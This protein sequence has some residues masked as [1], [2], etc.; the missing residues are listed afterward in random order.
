M[1]NETSAIPLSCIDITW[2]M[3]LFVRLV[4][5]DSGGS[6]SKLSMR[7]QIPTVG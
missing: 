6:V 2:L 7:R 3:Y 1:I 4:V 5:I